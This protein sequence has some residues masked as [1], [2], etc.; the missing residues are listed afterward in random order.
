MCV[1]ICELCDKF[2]LG[3]F[4]DGPVLPTKINEEFRPFMRRLPEF[5]FWY[6]A[7]YVVASDSFVACMWCNFRLSVVK[8]I[9]FS[10]GC[11]FFSALDI[12]VFWPILVMYFI[13]LFSITMKRQI[14]VQRG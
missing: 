14:K 4:L 8:A 6:F 5:K 9:L 7:G 3:N 10:T 1:C 12:P 11:T 13:L 2:V